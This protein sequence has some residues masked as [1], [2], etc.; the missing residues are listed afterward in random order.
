MI[1][2]PIAVSCLA[3]A[4]L[5]TAPVRAQGVVVDRV[6]AVVDGQVVTLS[7]VRTARALRL[8]NAGEEPAVLDALIDRLLV[9]A[10]ATRYGVQE[11]TAGTIEA[12]IAA[13]KQTL[14]EERVRALLREGGWSEAVLRQHVRDDSI[15]ASYLEQRFAA[16]GMPTDSEVD[17]YVQAHRDQLP[18][19]PGD[20]RSGSDAVRIARDRL[21]SERRARLVADWIGGLR[22]RADIRLTPVTP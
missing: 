19:A 8:V 18:A 11:P 22:R 16:T 12:T 10:E 21:A 6:L 1:R 14:G 9:V 20:E 5:A 2:A 15:A 3:V 7:D 4:A 17:A 13:L